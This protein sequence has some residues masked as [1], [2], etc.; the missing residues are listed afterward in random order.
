GVSKRPTRPRTHRGREGRNRQRRRRRSAPVEQVGRRWTRRGHLGR[1][2]EAAAVAG[3]AGLPVT[4]VAP[5]LLL[6]RPPWLVPGH[7]PRIGI[8][9]TAQ[10]LLQF[11]YLDLGRRAR[12]Q[13]VLLRKC[14]GC[15]IV[16][17]V[18]VT[19]RKKRYHDPACKNRRAFQKWYSHP[20][21]RRAHNARRSMSSRPNRRRVSRRTVART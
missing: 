10:S 11:L 12:E 21:N 5:R 8:V 4:V 19:N 18:A 7:A 6:G 15:P 17:P 13:Q 3:P 20:R 14:K 1:E 2:P 16:F 9:A